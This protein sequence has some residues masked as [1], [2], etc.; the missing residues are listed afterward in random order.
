MHRIQTFSVL[1]YKFFTVPW[2]VIPAKGPLA[3]KSSNAAISVL[4]SAYLAGRQA[5]GIQR[6]RS[7]DAGQPAL[8]FLDDLRLERAGPVPR[9]INLDVPGHV[10]Q[11]GF[12]P[13]A[14]A[15]SEGWS[16]S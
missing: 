11:H 3:I 12:R 16:L 4:M 5:F 8:V 9:H 15:P 10:S 2:L 13:T 7:L 14:V 1:M 6:A